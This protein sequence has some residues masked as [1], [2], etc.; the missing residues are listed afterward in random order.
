MKKQEPLNLDT[1]ELTDT[2]P[3][4]GMEDKRRLLDITIFR[5]RVKRIIRAVTLG[6]F[7]FQ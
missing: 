6:G 2:A 4:C 5:E 1:S 7:R 3:P